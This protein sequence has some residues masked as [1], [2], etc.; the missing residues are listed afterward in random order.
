MSKIKEIFFNKKTSEIISQLFTINTLILDFLKSFINNNLKIS[1][2]RIEIVKNDVEKNNET[3]LSIK[4]SGNRKTTPG[5]LLVYELYNIA[6]RA[7]RSIEL[8]QAGTKNE[9]E[10]NQL[11]N[12]IYHFIDDTRSK[13]IQLKNLPY[14][15]IGITV[16]GYI[17]SFIPFFNLLSIV[18]GGYMAFSHDRRSQ[19][20]GILMIMMTIIII[21]FSLWIK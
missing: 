13:E 21:L 6:V 11:F 8:F 14:P 17:L 16:A 3:L 18:F 20:N 10:I 5:T 19:I 9:Y 7:K 2:D 1:K 12:D 15:N 4:K